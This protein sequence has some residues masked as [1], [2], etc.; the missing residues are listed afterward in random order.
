VLTVESSAF[1]ESVLSALEC[2]D[3]DVTVF[4]ITVEPVGSNKV[5]HWSAFIVH[6]SKQIFLTSESSLPLCKQSLVAVLDVAEQL[7]VY[8][9]F[10]CVLRDTPDSAVLVDEF[11]SMG[12]KHLSPRLQPLPD[13]TVLRFDF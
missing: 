6:S 10:V 9:A 2:K 11:S 3:K 13:F 1:S 4:A 5:S 7:G 8:E 12:F